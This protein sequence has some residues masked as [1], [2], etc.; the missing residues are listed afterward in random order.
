MRIISQLLLTFLLNSLWQIALIASLAAVGSWLLRELATR[1][2]HW[3]WVSALCLAFLVPAITSLRT[4][5][6][7]VSASTPTTYAILAS[8]ELQPFPTAAAETGFPLPSTFQLDQR[9]G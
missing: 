2:R 8:E 9:L 7:T 5:G 3:I 6:D 4:L 1:Y